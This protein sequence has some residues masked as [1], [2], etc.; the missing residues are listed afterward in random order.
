MIEHAGACVDVA[1]W[2]EICQFLFLEADLLDRRDYDRWLGLI[3]EDMRY[4]VPTRVN[5]M[6]R[7]VKHEFSNDHELALFDETKRQ[8]EQRVLKYRATANWAENPPS[9]T[10]HL[11]AN[12]RAETTALADEYRV[13][14]AVIIHRNLRERDEQTLYGSRIDLLRRKAGNVGSFELFGREVRLESATLNAHN[15]SILL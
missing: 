3:A 8:L 13:E 10:R 15:L 2:H 9:R 5:R 7:E 1:S 4:Y 12:V 11:V 14:S 6:M